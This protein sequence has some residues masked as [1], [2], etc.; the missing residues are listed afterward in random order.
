VVILLSSWGL[1]KDSVIL[2]LDGV[3]RGVN[4]EKIKEEILQCKDVQTV[5]HIHVWAISTTENALTAHIV[6]PK[7]FHLSDF[8]SLKDQIKERLS[9]SGI[10]HSTLEVETGNVLC[11]DEDF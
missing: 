2:A 3:P 1:L 7:E 10:Q 4:L 5:H 6:V 11:P 9:K 8:E